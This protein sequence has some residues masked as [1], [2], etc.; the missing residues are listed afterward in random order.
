M[1]MYGVF[2]PLDPQPDYASIDEF[3]ADWD[4]RQH[5]EAG[6]S[7]V[8]AFRDAAGSAF[9]IGKGKGTRAHNADQHRH[10]RLGYY[11]AEFLAGIYTVDILKR[12]LSNDDAELLE[13]MLIQ[14]FAGQLVNWENN[15]GSL[16]GSLGQMRDMAG[17]LRTRARE[18]AAEDR[19]EEAV[20]ICREAV[21][22]V[23]KYEQT[24]HETEVLE[25]ERL[26]PS[27]LAAR[28]DLQ[29]AQRD[30]V[31]HA[32][33]LACEAFSD[34]TR[35]LCALGRAEEALREVEVFTL[36]YPHGSFREYEVLDHRYGRSIRSSLTNR[37]QA[38]LRRIERALGHTGERTGRKPI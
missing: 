26:A 36:R 37:E 21:A 6:S 22:Y 20:S 33:V 31:P 8:Y 7:Y 30:Y 24:E 18:A 12:G 38:T 34:L 19:F 29:R 23:S 27:S 16:R 10:G 5:D 25:L 35:Y 9:Y 28:V 17:S 32:P 14:S 13:A 1:T 11:I 15:L 4:R 3:L 2:D